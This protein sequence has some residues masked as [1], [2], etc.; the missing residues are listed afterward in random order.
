MIDFHNHVLPN[1]DDGPKSI[2]ESMEM[3]KHANIQGITDIVQTVHFQHPKMDGKNVTYDFLKQK[4]QLL[5]NEINKN[6]LNIKL[7]L[8]AEVFYLPNLNQIANN[9]LLTIGDG[10]YMLVEFSSNIYPSGYED[11]FFKLQSNGVT[12]IIAHPE[13]Y[14]FIQD[15]INILN[16]WIDR[17]YIIQ[18][19]AGSIIGQFGKSTKKITNEIINKGYFHLIGSDAHNNK[20]RNFCI[21][22]AYD[23]LENVYSIKLVDNLKNNASNILNSG[24]IIDIYSYLSEKIYQNK[25][26]KLK[27]KLLKF[28]RL[29]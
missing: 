3:L 19:D 25:L 24:D 7:H 28:I 2:E 5:Q 18:V 23:Y 22:D 16:T 27:E 13:R 14:R 11:V 26:Y 4:T 17:G 20:K 8:A 15:D 29:S 12:P 10:K 1:V 6:K 9:P 21:K